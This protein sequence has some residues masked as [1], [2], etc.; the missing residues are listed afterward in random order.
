[1]LNDPRGDSGKSLPPA[2]AMGDSPCD[3]RRLYDGDIDGC[4]NAISVGSIPAMGPS[5][6]PANTLVTTTT[7]APPS[8][9]CLGRLRTGVPGL[10]GIRDGDDA[11]GLVGSVEPETRTGSSWSAQGSLDVP[12]FQPAVVEYPA[13]VGFGIIDAL[14]VVG[15]EV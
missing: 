7:R 3:P 6:Q 10:F 15:C 13:N 2:D 14:A 5:S 9:V 4:R 1:M 8:A 12:A 11:N